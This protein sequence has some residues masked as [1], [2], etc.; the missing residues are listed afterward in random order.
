[1]KLECGCIAGSCRY[2]ESS[3]FDVMI[4]HPIVNGVGGFGEADI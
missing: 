4:E 2:M 3:G 1:M